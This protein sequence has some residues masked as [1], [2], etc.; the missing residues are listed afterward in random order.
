MK[1]AKQILIVGT[2][3]D[4][5][6]SYVTCKLIAQKQRDNRKVNVIKPVVSGFDANDDNCDTVRIIKQLGDELV[7]SN[8]EKISPFRL[9][10]PLS[11]ITAARN[12]NVTIEYSQVLDFCQQAV[13]QSKSQNVDLIIETAG[14]VMTPICAGKTF[15]DLASD[16]DIEIYLVGACFLGGISAILS[17]YENLKHKNCKK[18]TILVNNH[19][20]FDQRFLKITDF[21]AELK[22][23]VDCEVFLVENFVK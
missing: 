6:K 12:E 9:K 8:I 7:E 15:L 23:F 17:A 3:T 2:S 4:I 22:I 20:D 5:G 13:I 21:L 14:G 1:K 16:L 18:I 10:D 19:L 11:P